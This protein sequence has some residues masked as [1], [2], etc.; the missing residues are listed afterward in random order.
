MSG[1]RT[2]DQEDGWIC[3]PE[4]DDLPCEAIWQHCDDC[5]GKGKIGRKVCSTCTGSAGGYCC[6]HDLAE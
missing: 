2:P 6:V 4:P 1:N 5:D 3:R